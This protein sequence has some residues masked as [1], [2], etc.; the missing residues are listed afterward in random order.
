MFLSCLDSA[1]GFANRCL[2][3][4]ISFEELDNF[5]K[6]V[7]FPFGEK[8]PKAF[9]A[10]RVKLGYEGLCHIKAFASECILAISVLVLFAAM[11]LVPNGLMIQE[12]KALFMLCQILDILSMG[13][14]AA[15]H[16]A[17]LPS[18]LFWIMDIGPFWGMLG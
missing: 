17:A 18:S 2:E 9:F 12:C 6:S 7:V 10:T 1:A 14:E 13:D 16:V 15:N 3:N 5:S 8:L 4:G 11:R